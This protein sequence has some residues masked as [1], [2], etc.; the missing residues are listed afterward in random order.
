MKIDSRGGKKIVRKLLHGLVPPEL[1]ERPKA[2]FAIPVGEWIKGPLRSWAE[3]LLDPG[4]ITSQGWLDAD[5]IQRRWR[6]HLAGQQ[7]STPALWTILM[8][9]SWLACDRGAFQRQAYC[10]HLDG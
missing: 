10:G 3:E 2:G 8:F 6:S 4:L 9:Q 5:L 7:D 1:V